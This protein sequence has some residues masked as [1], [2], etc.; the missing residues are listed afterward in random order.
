MKAPRGT[1]PLLGLAILLSASC[2]PPRTPDA[3][4][5]DSSGKGVPPPSSVS[6]GGTSSP[7]PTAAEAPL[8]RPDPTGTVAFPFDLTLKNRDGKSVT[9]QV[10]AKRGGEI[11][12]FRD[13][14]GTRFVVPFALLS[15]EDAAYLS[16]F[17]DT[18]AEV[19]DDLKNPRRNVPATSAR[20]AEARPSP[21]P[22]T[23]SRKARWTE[24]F[25]EASRE[26]AESH[27]PMLLLFTGSDWC[28]YCIKLERDVFRKRE[29]Q[30]FAN[31]N[32]TLMKAD[33]PSGRV[34]RGVREQ[35]EELKAKYGVSGFPTV[36]FLSP[37]GDVLGSFS[38]YGGKGIG[39]FLSKANPLVAQGK[40]AA[41]TDAAAE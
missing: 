32:L 38:G 39:D 9:G 5:V 40:A 28:P 33:F 20:V 2:Q 41:T 12:F 26:S 17:P 25:E 1:L 27:L 10:L 8:T 13:L 36:V 30:E 23:A 35:N 22:D 37:K 16:R 24:N 4:A 14:D 34:R 18:R 6:L 29:F 31:Q 11:A 21:A 15:P 3:K 7:P 19:I